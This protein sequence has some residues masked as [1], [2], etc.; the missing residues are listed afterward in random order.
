MTLRLRQGSLCRVTLWA[1]AR[2]RLRE[3][4]LQPGMT[5]LAGAAGFTRLFENA[6]DTMQIQPLLEST[7][8]IL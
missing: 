3:V 4:D 1:G 7:S 2:V 5:S 8:C 6:M